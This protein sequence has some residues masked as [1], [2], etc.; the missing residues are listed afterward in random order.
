M[1]ALAPGVVL[2]ESAIDIERNSFLF[3]IALGDLT[4]DGKPE[5]IYRGGN[6]SNERR[7]MIRWN[8][9]TP[10]VFSVNSAHTL[11][12]F[13]TYRVPMIP[14]DVDGKAL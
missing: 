12:N 3:D 5:V 11:I 13:D 9:S 14:I 7:I 1:P 4:G 2:F 10:G 8:S 6:G